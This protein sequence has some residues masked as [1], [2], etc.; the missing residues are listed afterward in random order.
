MNMNMFHWQFFTLATHARRGS[1][2]LLA[3]AAVPVAVEAVPETL[4][5][6]TLSVA[7]SVLELVLAL[8]DAT[9]SPRI[10]SHRSSRD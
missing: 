7:Q 1:A 4:G 2:F 3:L 9:L 8:L 6:Q 5:L 10:V